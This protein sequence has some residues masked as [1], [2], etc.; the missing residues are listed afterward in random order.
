MDN[1]PI[2]A[3]VM[4]KLAAQ[5]AKGLAKYGEYVT[6]SALSLGEWLEHLQEELLDAAIY[7]E[8]I[9]AKSKQT[10]TK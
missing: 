7:V 8:C 3:A 1:N 9:R 10:I 2:I 6:P 5:Q 4:T